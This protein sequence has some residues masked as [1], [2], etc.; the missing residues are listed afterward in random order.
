ML[1]LGL[2]AGSVAG[3]VAHR[4]VIGPG[5]KSLV[6]EDAHDNSASTPLA[7]SAGV[8]SSASAL[9]RRIDPSSADS[10][11]A[12]P[13]SG[14][15]IAPAVAVGA[16]LLAKGNS[17]ANASTVEASEALVASIQTPSIDDL[18]D[19]TSVRCTFGPG[20]GGSWPG[21]KLTVGDAAWQGG[22]VDLQS[23]NYDAGTS[24][25][26]GQVTHSPTDGVPAAVALSESDVTFTARAANGALTVISVF[27]NFDNARHH[28]AVMSL[29]DGKHQLDVAQFYGSCDSTQKTLS[30][31]SQQ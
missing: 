9:R 28:R 15:S 3:W 31:A 2:I 23:I 6:R 17:R 4:A 18:R 16:S 7:Q 10:R 30:P 20:N 8:K 12:T 21:G 22:P 1:L 29:H 26:L 24:Q 27:G 19:A 25:M 13:A 5:S 14:S 11:S